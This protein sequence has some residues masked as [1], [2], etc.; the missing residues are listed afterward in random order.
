MAPPSTASST[1]A[2]LP[3]ADSATE[4]FRG[5][6]WTVAVEVTYAQYGE[7]GSVD[8]LA[9]R[10]DLGVCLVVELKTELVSIEDLVRRLD[11]KS[12][13]GSTI[14]LDRFGWRPRRAARLVILLEGS[15]NRRRVSR[16][17]AALDA[18]FPDRTD[19][20][21]A[22]LRQPEGALSGLMFLPPTRPQNAG[23]RI[24]SSRRVPSPQAAALVTRSRTNRGSNRSQPVTG[25]AT[26]T[27]R[28]RP[29][30]AGR[31]TDNEST[32]LRFRM[33]PMGR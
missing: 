19:G 17:V 5:L 12:R 13:L 33:L 4:W 27:G 29:G 16:H 23:S 31:V 21:R 10:A 28:P 14:H 25:A 6:G 8:L 15:T 26:V 18:A 2:T 32:K 3:P 24:V 9:S 11:A 22:W 7:R 30:C 1:S 20:V